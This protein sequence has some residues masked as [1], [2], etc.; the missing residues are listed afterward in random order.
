[1]M[2]E[3]LIVFMLQAFLWL[4]NVLGFARRDVMAGGLGF[5]SQVYAVGLS[6]CCH[7]DT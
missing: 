2:G 4:E 7:A 5:G 1:M 3:C 6:D